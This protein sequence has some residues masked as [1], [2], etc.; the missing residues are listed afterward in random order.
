M[1]ETTRQRWNRINGTLENRERE[2]ARRVFSN[3]EDDTLFH[4]PCS[5]II[6][7]F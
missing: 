4:F 6:F 7:K 5:K 3:E 1:I 2:K